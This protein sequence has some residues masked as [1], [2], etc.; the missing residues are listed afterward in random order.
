VEGGELIFGGFD[1]DY[2]DDEFMYVNVTRKGYWQ[3]T[4]D[5]YVIIFEIMYMSTIWT[6]SWHMVY[7]VQIK[8]NIL[9]TNG[10][11][12][13]VDTGTSQIAGP[14]S[15]IA[16]IN[17]EIGATIVNGEPLVNNRSLFSDSFQ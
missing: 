12:A 15:D 5:K 11:Q 4:M 16:I 17:K 8:N 3:F 10:C 2:H 13:F 6:I 14:S 9:C 1:P 7:R